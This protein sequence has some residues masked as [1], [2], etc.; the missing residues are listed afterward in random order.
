MQCTN[1]LKQ[2]GLAFHTF[3]DTQNGIPPACV[4]IGITPAIP[5]PPSFVTQRPNEPDWWRWNRVTV[6]PL[7]Y[8]YIEQTALYDLYASGTASDGS[9][10]FNRWF[11]NNWWT[12]LDA[13]AKKMHA[14]VPIM[15]CPSRRSAGAYAD[16]TDGA[17]DADNETWRVAGGP[18]GDY[19]MVFALVIN[20]NDPF[21][22]WH[23]GGSNPQNNYQRGPF[24]Q[25]ILTNGDGNSWKPQDTISRLAD[26]TSNQVLFGEKHIPLGQVGQC[27]S[28]GISLGDCSYLNIGENR[29][30]ASARIVRHFFPFFTGPTGDVSPGIVTPKTQGNTENYNAAFGSSHP[31][32]CNFVF[33]DGAVRGLSVTIQPATLAALGM[34]SDGLSVSY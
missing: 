11:G 12:S 34:V 28:E 21:P 31:G 22:W 30:P 27:K 26:G 19:A 17:S 9:M 10:G 15:V 20:T 32:T 6:Y 5:L 7:L 33:G 1:H 14:S 29:T 13:T 25:A 24:R 23:V 16:S 18:A 3:H 2:F 4:G 8:P